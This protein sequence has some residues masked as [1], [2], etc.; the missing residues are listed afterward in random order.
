M[1]RDNISRFFLSLF[2][3][4]CAA[5]A[6]LGQGTASRVTGIVLDSSGAAVPGATVTL[7]NEDTKVSLNT[8]TTSSGVYVFDSVQVGT[9][10]VA[11]EKQGFKKFISGGNKLNVNQP[12]T[13]NVTLDIGEIT[14]QVVVE[15]A[16]EL[17]QTS[18]SGNFGNTV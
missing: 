12:M 8:E 7:T 4:L 13:V 2:I 14:E 6:V 10:T 3:A 11:V 5:G 17:V 18:S 16:A 1:K 15:S 9:Y